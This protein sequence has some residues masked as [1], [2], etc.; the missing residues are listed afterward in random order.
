M[1][2]VMNQIRLLKSF[3]STTHMTNWITIGLDWLHHC[4]S[5]GTTKSKD[6]VVG[7]LNKAVVTTQID[8]TAWV[9][10]SWRR[11]H[12]E[13]PR[14]VVMVELIKGMTTMTAVTIIVAKILG[15]CI[16][17][18]I[19]QDRGEMIPSGWISWMTLIHYKRCTSFFP[20]R[21]HNKL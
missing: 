16:Q 14:V 15:G 20:P 17:W 4:R 5:R 2:V 7:V 3:Q 10:L 1:T 6:V 21:S 11:Y 19:M 8:R 9:Y 13:K 18:Y 12:W